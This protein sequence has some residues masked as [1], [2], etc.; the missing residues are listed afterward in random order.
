MA[1]RSSIPA[2]RI[3]EMEKPGRLQSTGSQRV[4]HDWVTSLHFFKLV[5]VK[6]ESFSP[7]TLCS[8]VGCVHGIFQAKVLEWVA[9]SFSRGS[10]WPRDQTRV[11]CIVGRSFTVWAT[12]LNWWIDSYS[13]VRNVQV[14]PER[15]KGIWKGRRRV[16]IG[17]LT[18]W[19][20]LFSVM[21]K[22]L[23]F[24]FYFILVF[25]DSFYACLLL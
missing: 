18:F 14:N 23:F 2:W 8:P 21:I 20:L 12:Y 24:K 11:S 1:T 4:G 25:L 10:S 9:I 16:F 22:S 17:C 6:E 13:L 19:F 15:K 7:A 3:P 5:K